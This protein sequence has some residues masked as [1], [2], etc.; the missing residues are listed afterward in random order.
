MQVNDVKVIL[1]GDGG[2]GKTS[3]VRALNNE[4]LIESKI[5]E[6]IEIQDIT[7]SQNDDKIRIKVWDFGG[8][9]IYHSI[10][11]LFLTKRTVYLIVLDSRQ[12]NN[13]I[14]WLN[15]V[16]KLIS[17]VPVIIA[18]NKIDA[19]PNFD[20]DQQRL[21][22]D[23]PEIV[24]FVKVSCKT[25]EGIKELKTLIFNT[26]QSIEFSKIVIPE[27]WIRVRS[28]IEQINRDYISNQ[29]FVEICKQNGI[30]EKEEQNTVSNYFHDLGIFIHFKNFQLYNTQILNPIWITE[31][32]YQLINSPEAHN[33]QGVLTELEVFNIFSSYK[34]EKHPKEKIGFILSLM[35]EFELIFR[36]D[37]NIYII[38][39]LLSNEAPMNRFI[40]ADSIKVIYKYDFL[41]KSLFNRVIVRTANQIGFEKIWRNGLQL[42]HFGGSANVENIQYERTIAISVSGRRKKELLFILREIVKNVNSTYE[43][44][45]VD[46]LIP[47]NKEES[48]TYISYAS[49]L[50]YQKYGKN[51][52]F[53]AL[54]GTEI[55]IN[56]LLKGVEPETEEKN[57]L[58]PIKIF[59]SYSH[60]DS[61]YKI[62]LLNHLSPL[63]RLDEIKVWQD[64][65]LVP[66]QNWESEIMERLKESDIVLCLISSDFISSDFCYSI[67]LDN[68]LKAHFRKEKVLI[69]IFIRACYWKKL[70]IAKIQGIPKIAISSQQNSDEGW[71]EVVIGIDKSIEKVRINKYD[72]QQRLKRP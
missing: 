41:P 70:P 47:L 64:G 71:E 29:E 45:K 42:N 22:L 15:T 68:A 32:I 46:E 4:K 16:Q 36:A 38:P 60:K 8:Q 6:G 37:K 67:E 11:Q 56:E 35:E 63:V 1:I 14:Y 10:H 50:A 48:S 28:Q 5:T 9:E 7:I 52:I 61:D 24:G 43:E 27:N 3:I 13:I 55:N 40:E 66:G 19:F 21:K 12:E 18:I 65:E 23:F 49:L 54:S 57:I 33:K 53:D 58:N 62:E 17:N 20:I 72:T 59:I 51:S 31:A 39:Q 30:T 69:P 2:V 25:L 26:A 44:I 34:N